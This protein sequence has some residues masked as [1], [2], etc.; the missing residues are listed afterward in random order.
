[1]ATIE[2]GIHELLLV[3]GGLM[4]GYREAIDA[5]RLLKITEERELTEIERV[6]LPYTMH[7]YNR[8]ELHDCID[9]WITYVSDYEYALGV[10]QKALEGEQGYHIIEQNDAGI[11]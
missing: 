6:M 10:V 5:L 1:M 2:L 11:V 4:K 3:R 8:E 7:K 9:D